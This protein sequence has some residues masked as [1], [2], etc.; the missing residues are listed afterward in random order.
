MW[1]LD[2]DRV[3]SSAEGL[4]EIQTGGSA[5]GLGERQRV[6]LE[7]VP[8]G[9]SA[10]LNSRVGEVKDAA[11]A[12]CSVGEVEEMPRRLGASSMRRQGPRPRKYH[13]AY[14]TI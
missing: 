11:A 4:I 6:K 5:D 1:C 10:G 13:R 8:S 12:T 14:I 2:L 9:V 7:E 3:C